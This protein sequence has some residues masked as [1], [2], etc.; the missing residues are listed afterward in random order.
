MTER[1]RRIRA[2]IDN[3]I[4]VNETWGE[5]TYLSRLLTADGQR[6]IFH[7]KGS[8]AGAIDAF[9]LV[10]GDGKFFDRFYVEMYHRHCSKKAPTGYTLLEFV[11]A[12]TG[13]SERVASVGSSVFDFDDKQAAKLIGT[14]RRGDNLNGKFLSKMTI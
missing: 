12:I 3:P 8:V 2:H 7:R 5:I 14:A 4:L 10:S 6:M 13:T 1:A 9:E 11:D